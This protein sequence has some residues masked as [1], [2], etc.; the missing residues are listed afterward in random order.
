MS[1]GD[2]FCWIRIIPWI[3]GNWLN[4]ISIG[5]TPLLSTSGSRFG[6]VGK[7]STRSKSRVG[8][9]RKR[10]PFLSFIIGYIHESIINQSNQ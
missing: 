7:D 10:F 8:G 4:T 1:I 9:I 2:I 6:V 5:A 3:A